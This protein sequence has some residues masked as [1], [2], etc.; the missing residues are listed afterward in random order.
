MGEEYSLIFEHYSKFEV[1]SEIVEFC[2]NRWVGIHCE[3][4]DDKGR[5]VLV[6]YFGAKKHPLKISS[7]KELEKVFSWLNKLKPRTVYATVNIYNRLHYLEDLYDSSNILACMPTWDIDNRLEDWN[8]TVKAAYEVISI[9][10]A[11]GVSKSF[12]IKFS[13]N[14]IHIHIH[15]YA[16]SED[17]RKKFNPLDLAWAIS[18][19]I[20]E[21]V[22][23]KVLDIALKLNAEKLKIENVIDPQRLFT[24]PLSIHREKLRVIVCLNPNKIDSFSPLQDASLKN[25]KHSFNWKEYV[26]GEADE[27]ALK[28]Y[29][30]IGFFPFKRRSRRKHPPL[31][32]QVIK[33]VRKADQM[34]S[35]K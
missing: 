33:F 9:L 14:G 7:I 13:G 32:K 15:P 26:E 27:L 18:E 3:S 23:P 17:V 16:I 12:F 30:N 28:A 10:E 19:Y 31:D 1:K 20:K 34:L 35:E 21:K 24:A 8:A 29:Q 11:N 5:K 22:S 2:K 4:R 6:R 25:F